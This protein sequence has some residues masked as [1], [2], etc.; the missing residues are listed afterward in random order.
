MA[1]LSDRARRGMTVYLL[2]MAAAVAIVSGFGV[3]ARGDGST[4]R[5]VTPRG[6]TVDIA[7][8]GVYVHNAER[9]VAEGVGWDLVTLL[10]VVPA[11]VLVARGVTR[12]SLR[13]RLM[14]IGLL[15]YLFY[16]YLMYAMAW[17][18]GPLLL[19]FV[20]LYAASLIGIAWFVSSIPLRELEGH[21]TERFP[22]RSMAVFSVTM[23][24]ILLGMWLPMIATVVD[25]ELDGV[26]Q[27]Q[28]TLVVQA[29]DLGLVVPVAIATAV[30][31][32][33][34]RPL[35]TL[36][37][38][39]LVVKGLAMSTAITA[40]VLSAWYVEGELDTA[41]LVI[42][43]AAAAACLLLTRS[44]YRAITE[45]PRERDGQQHP[46]SVLR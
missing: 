11:L 5:H 2:V 24:L 14:A 1:P 38:A 46:A 31:V 35:G 28:T 30:L 15:A 17:A 9:V 33:R 20:G 37:A 32:W 22:R 6:E 42:F 40:M 39:A 19:P 29:L 21:V 3:F 18:V 41:G 34:R 7:T 44:M 4:A 25:G 27:G 10:L 13:A 12:G 23:A 45:E 43:V 8:S 16:Q 26:L 36:L